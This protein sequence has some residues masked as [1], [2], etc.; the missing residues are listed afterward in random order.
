MKLYRNI[1]NL[2]MA[3]P[4]FSGFKQ[5]DGEDSRT[6]TREESR[7]EQGHT[8]SKFITTWEWRGERLKVVITPCG[9]L[10]RVTMT[11]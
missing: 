8:V 9:R 10:V 6:D 5:V 7:K 4:Y 2:R 3:I 1:L 11:S